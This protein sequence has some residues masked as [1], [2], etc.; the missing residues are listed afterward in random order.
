MVDKIKDSLKIAPIYIGL[1]LL[2]SL[3]VSTVVHEASF[4]ETVN[5]N[6]TIN[7]SMTLTI[8][9]DT[10]SL[11]LNPSTSPFA[12]SSITTTV[13]T[14]NQYGYTLTMKSSDGGTDLKEQDDS[15]RVISTLAAETTA[16]DFET[17]A[18]ARWGY[19]K[20]SGNYLPFVSGVEIS[21][22]D[23]AVNADVTN[24]TFGAKTDYMTPAGT[25]KITLNFAAVGKTGVQ[26]MQDMASSYCTSTPTIAVDSRDS[27]EYTI[28]RLADGKCW[29]IS[30][31]N[32]TGGTALYSNT[33]NVPDGYPSSGG[34]AY[35]TLPQ[36]SSTGF[37]DNAVAYVYNTG[38][39]TSSQSDCTSSQACN[40][41]YSWVAAVAGNQTNVTSDGG[42]A[43]YSICP[44]GWKLPSATTDGVSRSSGGYTGGDFFALT[45]NYG[46]ST[47][48][49]YENTAN[50]YSQA[51]PG[52]TPNFLLA[53]YYDNSQPKEVGSLGDYWSSSSYSSTRAYSLFLDSSRVNS[54]ND[55]NRRY[56]FPVRCILE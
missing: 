21:S 31:L 6:L 38:N 37:S 53:G 54:A 28:A 42:K 7:D 5:Y 13:G 1:A 46:M 15:T 23:A 8:P 32:L 44:K 55:N 22:S 34:T 11:N 9:T 33:S 52:T 39:E 14:N 27:K 50:F 51:G 43:P 36:S 2:I 10:I 45:T 41:Y 4:A 17:L 24:L 30:N 29:M 26:Y 25:Y 48:S 16:A 40:S 56:G 35:Y 47:S 49:Y 12:T 19:A 3:I 18:G 20:N